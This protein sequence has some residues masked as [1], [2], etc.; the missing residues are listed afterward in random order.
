V[1]NPF[2]PTTVV[3]FDVPQ[4]THVRLAI[5]DVSGTLIRT[6]LDQQLEP[7]HKRVTWDGKD[8]AGGDVASGVYFYRLET[9]AFSSTRKMIL[10]R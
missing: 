2:N 7:G 5:Y 6:L 4:P 10:L 1:P 9:T 3:A 8:A